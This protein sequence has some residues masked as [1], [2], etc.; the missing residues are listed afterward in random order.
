MI[1]AN[2]LLLL[3]IFSV[4]SYP[5]ITKLNFFKAHIPRFSF[6]KAKFHYRITILLKSIHCCK[7]GNLPIIVPQSVRQIFL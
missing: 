6:I 7:H 2:K 5:E 1:P 4:N 3:D